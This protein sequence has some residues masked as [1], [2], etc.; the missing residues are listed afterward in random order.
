VRCSPDG[1][2][3]VEIDFDREAGRLMDAPLTLA[4]GEELELRI[5]VD[6]SVIEVF[7]NGR[8]CQTARFYPEREDCRH[9]ALFARGGG[10]EVLA[11]QAWEMRSIAG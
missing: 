4:P 10:A 11:I 3:G 5:F 1:A 7:A 6:R 9:V 8:A 2:E